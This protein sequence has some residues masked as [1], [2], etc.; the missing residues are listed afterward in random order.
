[1]AGAGGCGSTLS[2]CGD[3][4]PAL[5]AQLTDALGTAVAP[6]G[7][8]Y[9]A[10]SGTGAL[11]R[12]RRVSALEPGIGTS[13][14]FI[15]SADGSLAYFFDSGGR[16]VQTLNALTGATLYSFVYDAAGRLAQVTDGNGLVTTIQRNG[17]G[18]PTAI[19]APNGQQTALSED[20][21]GYL[22][23]IVDPAGH[24]LGMTYT[25]GG[26]LT[27]LT[28]PRGHTTTMNYDA[29]G[30]L[31]KD[32]DPL[33]GFSALARV[34]SSG[35]YTVALTSALTHTTLYRVEN[36][37]NGDQRHTNTDAAGLQSSTISRVDS[38]RIITAPDGTLLQALA[39]PDPRW[40]L[41]AP[42]ARALT[43][44]LPSG[45]RQTLVLTHGASISDSA[46]IFSLLRLTETVALNNRTSMAIYDA[47]ARTSTS[48]S[49]AGRQSTAI[50]DALGRLVQ[51]TVPG[52]LPLASTFDGRGRLS[53]V[54][55]GGRTLLFNYDVL[56]RLNSVT[57]PLGRWSESFGTTPPTVSSARRCP[58]DAR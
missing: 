12:I 15:P 14:V 49:P 56:D 42:N 24:A 1:M 22:T 8:L 45:L 13:N 7:A 20:A 48:T 28:D 55:Q 47:A 51:S 46:N 36:L 34:D 6:D 52:V 30:R 21:N 19:V 35:G 23:S 58:V 3:G 32:Q 26:L 39:A 37:P 40:S 16:H 4:G 43:T 50:F 57:D 33:A 44:T 54:T 18:V 5:G 11:N 2:G 31:L 53:Q 41:F 17:A 29:V 25:A 10:E 27:G 38:S 9:I